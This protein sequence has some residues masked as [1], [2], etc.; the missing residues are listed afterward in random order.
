MT[1]EDDDNM[2]TM[3]TMTTRNNCRTDDLDLN[4]AA[5]T[6]HGHAATIDTTKNCKAS[7]STPA[8]HYAKRHVT[9]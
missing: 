7:L 3:T 4:T 9:S 8:L 2:T 1:I 5:T 6:H